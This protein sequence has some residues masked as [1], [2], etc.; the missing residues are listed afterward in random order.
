MRE[1][2][3]FQCPECGTTSPIGISCDR[4]R[5]PMIDENGNPPLRPALPRPKWVT[6]MWTV[7]G[8]I[9]IG[10]GWFLLRVSSEREVIPGLFLASL[11]VMAL[12]L[13]LIALGAFIPR[14]RDHRELVG[15]LARVERLKR[16]AAL[17]SSIAGA[18]PGLVRVRGRVKVLAPAPHSGA[19]TSCAAFQTSPSEKECGRFA[20][21]DGGGVALVDDDCFE[22]WRGG[23]NRG[24]VT[25]GTEI[26]VIG[27]ASLAPVPE[28]ALLVTAYRQ[29]Q[30][31]LVFN[32]TL[33]TPVLL[34]LG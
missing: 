15:R 27:G 14:A 11:A 25:E 18:Q 12:G 33:E 30:K 5:V 13:A 21:L 31:V 32:G 20:V 16:G 10:G 6:S 19:G 2:S 34:V 1:G 9:V 29:D 28:A 26:E 8:A 24:E 22:V 23:D 7:S 4:C 17:A 3:R